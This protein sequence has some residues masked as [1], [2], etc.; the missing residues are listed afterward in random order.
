MLDNLWW[1]LYKNTSFISFISSRSYSTN[2][3]LHVL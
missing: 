1:D 3:V 2:L